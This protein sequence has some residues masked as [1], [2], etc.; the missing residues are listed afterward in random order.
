MAIDLSP[1][2]TSWKGPDGHPTKTT[3]LMGSD[4]KPKLIFGKY[5]YV[6][7]PHYLG[8]VWGDVLRIYA[9]V[10][11]SIK[12]PFGKIWF[13]TFSKHL[14]EIQEKDSLMAATFLYPWVP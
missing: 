5:T 12:L 7:D 6:N 13:G 8:F 11:I 2:V 10:N 3:P 4:I 9:M 14:K 1:V